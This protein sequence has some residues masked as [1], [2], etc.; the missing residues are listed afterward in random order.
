MNAEAIEDPRDPLRIDREYSALNGLEGPSSKP[1]VGSGRSKRTA[2]RARRESD[3]KSRSQT[4]IG[5]AVA[6]SSLEAAR[7]MLRELVGSSVAQQNCQ[8]H[9]WEVQDRS[10]VLKGGYL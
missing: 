6:P 1:S 8:P 3:V 2:K 7:D 5:E 10:L 9:C 4:S